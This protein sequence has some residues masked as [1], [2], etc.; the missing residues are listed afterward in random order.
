MRVTNV[1]LVALLALALAGCSFLPLPARV[2]LRAELGAE[3]AGILEEE[4]TAG[5][6]DRL[7]LRHP[8]D[9]GECVDFSEVDV[10]ITVQ[11]AQLNY[12]ADLDYDGPDLSGMLNAQLFAWAEGDEAWLDRNRVGP[13]VTVNLDRTSTRLAGSAVLSKDQLRAVNDRSI[14]WGLWVTGRDVTAA[15]SGTATFEYDIQQLML[16]IRFSV[17]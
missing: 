15:E 2:D 3:S 17:I 5:R 16:N 7:D 10:P 13:T 8:T 11:S 6:N 9:E 4:I 12:R 1:W 14:C